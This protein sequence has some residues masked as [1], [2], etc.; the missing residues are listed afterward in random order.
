MKD[1]GYEASEIAAVLEQ[2]SYH[3]P[4]EELKIPDLTTPISFSEPPMPENL[5][6]P[7]EFVATGSTAEDAAFLEQVTE[8][9]YAYLRLKWGKTYRP[10]EWIALE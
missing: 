4:T 6:P 1:Q 10:E 2:S 3:L 7:D 5:S 9:E 8:E